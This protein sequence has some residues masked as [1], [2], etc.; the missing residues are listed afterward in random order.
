MNEISQRELFEDTKPAD[1]EEAADFYLS[2]HSRGDVFDDSYHKKAFLPP[3]PAKFF[4][5]S[6]DAF[7]AVV[8]ARLSGFPIEGE[9]SRF[10]E[11]VGKAGNREAAAR[12]AS[13]RGDPDVLAVLT[14][15]CK[16]LGEIHR[17][18]GLLRFSSGHD[19]V[20]IAKCSPDHFILPA[21]SEHFTIR[22]GETSWAIIDEK[23]GLCLS[24]IN[25]GQ[26][27]LAALS[28]APPLSTAGKEPENYWEELWQQYH[29]SINNED[30]KNPRLQRQFMPERY[31][32]YLPEI[33]P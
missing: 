8:H 19:G 4:E 17:M 20:Y 1:R 27:R 32:K 7:F 11:K 26:A 29:R 16:V 15:A 23:R 30:R 28:S 25:G 24:R 10:I 22:F 6:M 2:G 18:E 31:H 21:L 9:I 12:L 33:K 13:D 14:A 5:L 3:H